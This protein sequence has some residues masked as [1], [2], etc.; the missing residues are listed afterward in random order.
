VDEERPSHVFGDDSGLP[1]VLDPL[2]GFDVSVKEFRV[3]PLVMVC[4]DD[5]APRSGE[6]PPELYIVLVLIITVLMTWA[7]EDKS[8]LPN[9][10]GGDTVLVTVTGEDVM[11]PLSMTIE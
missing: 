3:I 2:P 5:G 4:D 1:D 10:G 6:L 9:L 8:V 7:P 11:N